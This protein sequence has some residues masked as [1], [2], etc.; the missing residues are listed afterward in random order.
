MYSFQKE[1]TV[2]ITSLLTILIGAL[3]ISGW[4]FNIPGFQNLFLHYVSMKFNTALCFIFL[5]AALLITQFQIK[6]YSRIVFLSLS[7]FI[8]LIGTA[9]VSQDLFHFNLGVDQ[10]FI[11]DKLAFTEKYPFPGRMSANTAVCFII[12]GLT[13]FGFSSRSIFIKNAVTISFAFGNSYFCYC[14]NWLPVQLVFIL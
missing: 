11:A 9:S 3:V 2:T 14:N 13:F 10:F 4:L 6:K 12:F 8:I 5:G 7:F 1:H